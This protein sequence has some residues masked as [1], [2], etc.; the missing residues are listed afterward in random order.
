MMGFGIGDAI[1]SKDGKMRGTVQALKFAN[2]G[3]EFAIVHRSDSGTLCAIRVVDAEL[4][5]AGSDRVRAYWWGQRVF[6]PAYRSSG[7]VDLADVPDDG[8]EVAV[9]LD[10]GKRVTVS[11]S[12]LYPLHEANKS[13]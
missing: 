10:S 7:R 6:V 3:G 9:L 2:G 8:P 13:G 12:Q 4:N 11:K 1:R 5:P